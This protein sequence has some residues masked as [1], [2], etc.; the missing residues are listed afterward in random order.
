MADRCKT[1]T[2]FV[3]ENMEHGDENE[4]NS[5]GA[6]TGDEDKAQMRMI[7]LCKR[8]CEEL[9]QLVRRR[10]QKSWLLG[11]YQKRKVIQS[12]K[13]ALSE[14]GKGLQELVNSNV[15]RL[16]MSLEAGEKR[17]RRKRISAHRS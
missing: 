6:E 12:N 7:L 4:E 5:S 15:K 11:V 14:V 16:K 2:S 3:N 9:P 8:K 17:K 13:H 1:E 10:A